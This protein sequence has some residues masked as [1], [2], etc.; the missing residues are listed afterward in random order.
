[1]SKL[2]FMLIILIIIFEQSDCIFI[3]RIN[4]SKESDKFDKVMSVMVKTLQNKLDNNE[5]TNNDLIKMKK[6]LQHIN[7]RRRI[8]VEAP[9]YWHSR[10]GRK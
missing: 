3:S 1:M 7:S 2:I 5:F 9:K 8:Q 10:Q 4:T 6:M